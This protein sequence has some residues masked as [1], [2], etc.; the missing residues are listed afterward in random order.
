MGIRDQDPS[1]MALVTRENQMARISRDFYKKT[2]E[3]LRANRVEARRLTKWGG[4]PDSG[5]GWPHLVPPHRHL[6]HDGF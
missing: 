2:L 3:G 1:I 6:L 4:Q 5:A